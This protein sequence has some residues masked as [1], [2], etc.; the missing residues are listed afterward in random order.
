MAKIYK[1]NGYFYH[2]T[3][4]ERLLFIRKNPSANNIIDSVIDECLKWGLFDTSKFKKYKILT[5]AGIQKRY[6][7][8]TDRREKVNIIQEY[9]LTD[10]SVNINAVSVNI[11]D[12]SGNISTQS[13]VEYS[14]VEKRKEQ[15]SEF[16]DL[17]DKK[18]DNKKCFD[19]WMKLKDSEIE[20]IF[21][22][23]PRY[24]AS[25]QDV[26][27]RKNPLTYLNGKCWQDEFIL[28]VDPKGVKIDRN[29]HPTFP[30]DYPYNERN[31]YFFDN[32]VPDKMIK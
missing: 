18:R 10:I 14:K 8:A 27:F 32:G 26:Q 28:N 21:E 29:K 30:S 5:S 16:W 25:T 7:T 9:I 31:I 4:K 24:I 15:Y 20:K 2:W 12:V 19:K 23:L 17:F 3:E 6:L 1:E 11:N 13:K 22:T